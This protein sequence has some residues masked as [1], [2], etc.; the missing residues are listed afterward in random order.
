M[1]KK[2]LYS[3]SRS[4]ETGSIPIVKWRDCSGVNDMGPEVNQTGVWALETG[5]FVV[6]I[7]YNEIYLIVK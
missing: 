6:R 1:I 5:V 4:C 2:K 3:N 7:I